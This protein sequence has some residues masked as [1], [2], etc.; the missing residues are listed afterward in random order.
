M[1]NVLIIGAGGAGQLA[2]LLIQNNERLKKIY[3]I[4]GFLDDNESLEYVLDFP[5][6]GKVFDAPDI[7]KK[8][9]IDEVLIAIPSARNDVIQRI[10]KVILP[11]RVSVKIVP[12]LYEIV[13]GTFD[14]RQ[15]RKVNLD[16]L[17]GREEV[18]FDIEKIS[19]FYLGKR[20]FV[21]GAGGSIGNEIVNQ[22]LK[23][24]VKEIMAFGHGENSIHLL[25]SRHKDDKRLK[26]TIG[27]IRDRKKLNY[28]VKNFKPDIIFHAAAHKHVYLME[29]CPDEAIKNNVIGTYNTAIVAVENNVKNFTLISTDKAVNPTSIMGATKRIAEK[30][31]L[32]LNQLNKTKFSLVR[33]G[34]VLG[35]RGSVGLIFK[36]QIENGGPITVTHPDVTRYFMS[37]RE[38]SR[39]VIKSLTI[40]IGNIFVL[41]MG[42]P[43]KIIDIAKNLLYMYG[44]NEDEIPIVFTGLKK[45]EKLHEEIMS[46]RENLHL[47]NFEKL[48]ISKENNV[49]FDLN[50]IEEIIKEFEDSANS[51]DRNKIVSTIKKYCEEYEEKND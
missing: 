22:L 37:I 14:L 2:V 45:G 42:K 26:Y 18:G 44:Y 50:K 23:L 30:I 25:I 48:Y 7:I 49:F 40:D 9:Q 46:K 47:S 13:E 43:V 28:E 21:T 17:L 6:L 8:Y 19:P 36:E 12:G 16:D 10:F 3:N 34:N 51:F 29:E 5:I 27:D 4:V 32:S 41:D 39:L 24:P 11:L 38:A 20:I 33:F 31:I 1:K 35:S 15:I